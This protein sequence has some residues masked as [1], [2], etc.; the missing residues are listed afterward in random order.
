MIAAGRGGLVPVCRARP[1]SSWHGPFCA[2][3][4]RDRCIRSPRVT[5]SGKTWLRVNRIWLAALLFPA[6]SLPPL[7]SSER[8]PFFLFGNIATHQTEPRAKAGFRRLW[9]RVSER[10]R[11]SE[12]AS[13][14]VSGC[15]VWVQYE[16]RS[17]MPSA[18]FIRSPG[19]R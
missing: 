6:L 17:T 9:C 13:L 15:E 7:P 4:L 14:N 12:R 5:P 8:R 10:L 16:L 11:L 3:E 18:Q 19:L 1:P 2:A